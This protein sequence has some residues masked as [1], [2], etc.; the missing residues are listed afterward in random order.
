MLP[1]RV[2]VDL[3]AIAIKKYSAFLKAP[4]LLEFHYQIA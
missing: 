4:A 1:L 2:R 3:A